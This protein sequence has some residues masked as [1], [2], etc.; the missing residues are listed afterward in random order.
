[1]RAKQTFLSLLNGS[2]FAYSG[3]NQ[4]TAGSMEFKSAG[5]R[6]PVLF[7]LIAYGYVWCKFTREGAFLF[8]HY[9]CLPTVQNLILPW[10]V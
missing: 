2:I 4:I 8:E 9:I 6:I 10:C 1:M 7:L 3:K 5:L